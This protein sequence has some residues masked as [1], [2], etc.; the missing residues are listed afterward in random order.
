VDNQSDK[1]LGKPCYD[2]I[3]DKLGALLM[4]QFINKGWIEKENA[5]DKHFFNTEKG[6][7]EF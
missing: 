1:R 7:K 3:G 6:Q 2:H 5:G 4:E